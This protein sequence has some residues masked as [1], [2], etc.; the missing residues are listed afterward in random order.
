MLNVLPKPY[1]VS[2]LPGMGCSMSGFS[3]F[4]DFSVFFGESLLGTF[5]RFSMQGMD[6]YE[7]HETGLGFRRRMTCCH[8]TNRTL[9]SESAPERTPTELPEVHGRWVPSSRSTLH[10]GP[11]L[12]S[13]LVLFH[14]VASSQDMPV[15]TDVPSPTS[16]R[17]EDEACFL[18]S[19]D[20]VDVSS[21]LMD[22][23]GWLGSEPIGGC[24]TSSRSRLFFGWGGA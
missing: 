2:S 14:R 15:P 19:G 18:G 22:L 21:T 8:S 13:R 20:V 3:G 5:F 16:L 1:P 23:K 9:R 11:L 12:G 4:A 17:S 10:K 7:E 24:S 6:K